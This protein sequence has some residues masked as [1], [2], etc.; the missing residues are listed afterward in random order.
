MTHLRFH[1]PSAVLGAVLVAGLAVTT[2][3][4]RAQEA[5]MGWEYRIVSDVSDDDLRKLAGEGWDFAGYLGEGTRG[6]R[7]DETLWKRPGQ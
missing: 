4:A 7:V 6:D 2:S 1:V 3:L 5:A